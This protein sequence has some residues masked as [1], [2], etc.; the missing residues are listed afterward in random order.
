MEDDGGIVATGQPTPPT[1]AA[2]RGMEMDRVD[3]APPH[4]RTP[5]VAALQLVSHRL[6]GRLRQHGGAM[7]PAQP[8]PDQRLDETPAAVARVLREICGIGCGGGGAPPPCR[9]P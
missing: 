1:G 3:A 7:E 2:A 9:G 6:A 5:D 8:L 4:D